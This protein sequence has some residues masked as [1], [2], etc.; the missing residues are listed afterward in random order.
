MDPFC[1]TESPKMHTRE[2][3]GNTKGLCR[4]YEGDMKGIY[5]RTIARECE[6]NAKEMQ[7]GCEDNIHEI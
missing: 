5:L 3:K 2:N 7:R 4:E 6:A 1:G